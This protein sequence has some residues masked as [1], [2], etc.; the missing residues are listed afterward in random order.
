MTTRILLVSPEKKVFKAVEDCFSKHKISTDWTDTAAK[1]LLKLLDENFDLIIL[2]E[3]L[4]DMNGRQLVE[5]IITQNAMLNCVVLSK[6]SKEDFHET[7][8]GLGVLMQFSLTPTQD[9]ARAL[10]DY[11][12]RIKMIS[13]RPHRITGDTNQ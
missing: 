2:H 9:D 12:A 1:A 10:I 5:K 4:Q 6:L 3:Q 8:E 13:K 7:Y 11:M